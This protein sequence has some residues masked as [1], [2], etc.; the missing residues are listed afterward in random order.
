L[1]KRKSHDQRQIRIGTIIALRVILMLVGLYL[2]YKFLYAISTVLLLLVLSIFFCY[3]VAPIVRLFEQPVY[4]G[5]REVKLPRG[6]AIMAVYAVMGV[7]LFVVLQFVVPVLRDQVTELGRNRIGY[8]ETATRSITR[9]VEDANNWI[10]H[11]K[12]PGQ[13]REYISEQIGHMAQRI[14]PWLEG[15]IGT[16]LGYLLYLPWLIII[17]LL[18]FFMLKDAERFEQT[19]VSLMPN[20]RLQKR[21]RWFLR[22]ISQTLA[23]YIRAQITACI[24]IGVLVTTGLAVIG[25]PYAL[26]LGVIAG[27]LEFLPMVGPLMSAIICITLALTVSF[28]LALWVALFLAVLRIV[29]DYIIYPRI[30]GHGIRMHP[31]LVIIAIF[32]GA[33]IGG[34]SGIFLAI[35]V[36]GLIL[37]GY[38][39]Y[40]AYKGI[41]GLGT[42]ADEN[43]EV[44]A[45]AEPQLSSGSSTP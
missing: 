26:V 11:L 39:H 35:P 6:A 44:A 5:G 19:I 1:D 2:I 15:V 42:E 43:T 9:T 7:L 29:Q 8:I 4:A 10:S 45:R 12:V 36:V 25:V 33:E 17:P 30:V 18:S 41:Q 24:E 3:L 37:V 21:A 13:G 34:L 31:L 16:L 28:K 23:A 32:A 14:V 40:L 20:E 27:M 22:D 38:N